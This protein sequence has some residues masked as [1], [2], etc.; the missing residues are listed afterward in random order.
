MPKIKSVHV[1]ANLIFIVKTNA[2]L[3]YQGC[4]NLSDFPVIV[5]L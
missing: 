2:V 4:M 3:I 1:Y 5:Y